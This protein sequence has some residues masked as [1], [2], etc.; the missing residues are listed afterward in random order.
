MK[1]PQNDAMGW[2]PVRLAAWP[3]WLGNPDPP[4]DLGT[5]NPS[6][7]G[8]AGFY[9][10]NGP[11]SEVGMVSPFFGMAGPGLPPGGRAFL[12]KIMCQAGSQGRG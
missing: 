9:A 12:A 7:K 2:F 8:P 4:C 6:F 5:W 10:L 3:G 1:Q 11:D